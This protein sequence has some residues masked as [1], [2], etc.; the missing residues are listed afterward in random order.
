MATRYSASLI[1]VGTPMRT[2]APCSSAARLAGSLRQQSTGG[3][4]DA[5]HGLGVGDLTTLDELDGFGKIYALDCEIGLLGLSCE[6]R[7]LVDLTKL[8]RQIH[9]RRLVRPTRAVGEAD[10]LLPLG[11]IDPG[12][13]DQLT[14]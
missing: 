10:Q 2:R 5:D 12:F 3:H 13:L 4:E 7:G 1:S 6:R 14:P 8:P 11:S 9:G